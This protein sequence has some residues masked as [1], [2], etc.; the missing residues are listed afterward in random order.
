MFRKVLVP[1]D[2]SEV[3]A[4]ILTFL[5]PIIE[6]KGASIVA[7]SV[8]SDPP[9]GPQGEASGA[10]SQGVDALQ[11]QS[12]AVSAI[13]RQ[14]DPAEEILAVA[15]SEGVSLIAMSTHGRTGISRLVRGSV[16]ERV[17]RSADT[18]VLLVNPFTKPHAQDSQISRILVPLDRSA[19]SAAVIPEVAQLAQAYSSHVTLFHVANPELHE[20][21]MAERRETERDKVFREQAAIHVRQLAEA[22]VQAT[23]KVVFEFGAAAQILAAVED[24]AIDLVALTTHGRSGM[25]RWLFGSVAEH[26]IRQCRAPLLVK[27]IAEAESR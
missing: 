23:V 9:P 12:A 15:C 8:E 1:L 17:L 3:S 22:G 24:Q 27:R 19:T 13:R 26:V 20:S 5:E 10:W 25:S 21:P 14:G 11:R 2:G 18:P 4:R 6:L 7:L 16:A